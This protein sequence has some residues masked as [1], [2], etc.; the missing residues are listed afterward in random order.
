MRLITLL[1]VASCATAGYDL[2]RDTGDVSHVVLPY[3]YFAKVATNL[4]ALQYIILLSP[5]LQE[6]GHCPFGVYYHY[7]DGTDN[8]F[9]PEWNAPGE[10]VLAAIRDDESRRGA[11]AAIPPGQVAITQGY[12][13]LDDFVKYCH[14]DNEHTDDEVITSCDKYHYSEF[15]VNFEDSIPPTDPKHWKGIDFPIPYGRIHVGIG[16]DGAL[17]PVNQL[18]IEET[19]ATSPDEFEEDGM[20]DGAVY[21]CCPTLSQICENNPPA[22]ATRIQSNFP[23]RKNRKLAD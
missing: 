8:R 23:I 10:C 4:G 16:S 14:T 1:S 20:Y 13:L 2:Y 9:R 17:R 5:L 15:F 21:E 19:N 18:N 3:Q 6:C 22:D 11:Q 7:E 12:I